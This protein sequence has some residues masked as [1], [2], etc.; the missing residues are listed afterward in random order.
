MRAK[1]WKHTLLAGLGWVVLELG[2][3]S[4]AE[5][6]ET[7]PFTINAP[8]AT[9]LPPQTVNVLTPQFDPALGT[10]QSGATTIAG[11]INMGLEFFNTGA[12]GS[13]DVLVDDT[14]SLAGIPGR[15]VEELT[16][17]VPPGQTAFITPGA[18]FPFGP[19]DRGDASAQVV[20]TETW[21]QVFSLPFPALTLKQSPSSVL[22]GIV[23]TG[24]SVTTY[25]YTPVV[26]AA[27]E[28]RLTGVLGLLLALGLVAAT[29]RERAMG[30]SRSS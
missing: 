16:G 5:I 6:T 3:A 12:G 8:G 19:V 9:N 13:Y 4:G 27:P 30:L 25:V 18:T 17:T 2:T 1:Y 23:I 26:T 24:T 15:F 11:T 21:N 14:L 22:P 10:F 20:G 28:P 7:V 29:G